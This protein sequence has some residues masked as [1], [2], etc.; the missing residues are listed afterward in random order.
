MHVPLLEEH[1]GLG[2]VLHAI[3]KLDEQVK[4]CKTAATNTMSH[5]MVPREVGIPNSFLGRQ[6]STHP[7]PPL[8]M[9]QTS[10]AVERTSYM[11]ALRTASN[12]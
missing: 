2:Q 3:E 11:Q 5:Y 10:A 9:R 7:V 1:Q 8:M 12:A 6:M 4:F